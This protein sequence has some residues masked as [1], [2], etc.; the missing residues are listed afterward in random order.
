MGVHGLHR[1]ATHRFGGCLRTRRSAAFSCRAAG[2]PPCGGQPFRRSLQCGMDDAQTLA[3]IPSGPGRSPADEPPAATLRR[4][5]EDEPPGGAGRIAA[6]ASDIPVVG[7][8]PG[9]TAAVI[10]TGGT[11]SVGAGVHRLQ[12]RLHDRCTA[13]PL[14]GTAR[15]LGR[16][17]RNRLDGARA[18][19]PH[20]RKPLPRFRRTGRPHRRG[21]RLV[22]LLLRLDGPAAARRA[23]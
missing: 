7:G 19:Q 8:A 17:D 14:R 9:I 2:C 10:A 11:A 15:S 20:P 5:E 18:H 16:R 13:P 6:G 12:G 3:A 1:G 4:S 22:H 21:A 23:G